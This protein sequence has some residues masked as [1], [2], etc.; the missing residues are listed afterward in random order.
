MSKLEK[1]EKINIKK[2]INDKLQVKNDIS[3]K[4]LLVLVAKA[5]K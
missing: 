4:V 2:A 5:I 1:N 3:R